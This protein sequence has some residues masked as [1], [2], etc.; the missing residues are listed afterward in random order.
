MPPSHGRDKIVVAAGRLVQGFGAGAEIAGATV[1][2]AEYAPVRRRGLVA[3]Q[4]AIATPLLIMAAPTPSTTA[5]A[6]Y[7]TGSCGV[8]PYSSAMPG[9]YFDEWQVGDRV[10]HSI[11]RTVTETDNLLISTLTHNPQPLHID[12]H[13]CEQETEWGQPLMNSLFTLGL[14]I[15]MSVSDI[16]TGTTISPTLDRT[17]TFSPVARSRCAASTGCIRIVHC[18]LPRRSR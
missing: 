5:V 3:A 18:G 17:N 10:E 2:L 1:L 7:T 16:S 6:T 15:G 11:S 13:F 14:M 8:M 9:R 4:F 12:R